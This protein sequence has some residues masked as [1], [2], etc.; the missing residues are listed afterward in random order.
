MTELVITDLLQ[1]L[2]EEN[3]NLIKDLN[4]T[5]KLLET[6]RSC[7]ICFTKNCKCPE[8]VENKTKFDKIEDY[9]NKINDRIAVKH[10]GLLKD[11]GADGQTDKQF[12]SNLKPKSKQTESKLQS[13]D[14]K[15]FENSGFLLKSTVKTLV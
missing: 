10:K 1:E 14:G 13:I 11:V 12:D 5:L 3:Y 7:L 9:F 2:R 4:L 6:Y 15:L 8:N